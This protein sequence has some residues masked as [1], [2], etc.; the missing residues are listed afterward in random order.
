MPSTSRLILPPR[1]LASCIAGCL[2]RDTRGTRLSDEERLNYF[3]ASPLFAASV[4]LSGDL[5]V[6]DTLVPLEAIKQIP[7]T[8]KTVFSAPKT[9][10]N[11]S[12]SPGPVEG[13]TVAFYP[14]AWQALGGGIDG[15]PPDFLP[16]VLTHFDNTTTEAA[17]PLFWDEMKRAWDA[18][19]NADGAQRWIGSDRVKTWTY[20][21]LGK[22]AQTGSG[23]SLRS[24]QRRIRRWTGQD[25]QTLSFFSRIEDLHQLVAKDP[26]TPPADLAVDAGFADQS[27]MGRDLKR[28]TGFSP[29]QLNQRIAEDEAF[30]C[31]RLLG[32]RF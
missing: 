9:F 4:M 20:H 22:A 31:Y 1:E 28:A 16:H 18:A 12:W 25:I 8:P 24:M 27:H 15:T 17:W 19:Q 23:R 5:H 21:L 13:F 7:R 6:A 3:P 32:E 10:P 26:H 30:W 29:A 11:M 14:D 2:Y